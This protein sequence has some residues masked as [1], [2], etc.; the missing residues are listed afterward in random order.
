VKEDLGQKF[1]ALTAMQAVKEGF[2][3]GLNA[4]K[5]GLNAM[6]IGKAFDVLTTGA[7]GDFVDHGR[8]ELA[9]ALFHGADPLRD[10]PTWHTRPGQ[11][12]AVARGASARNHPKPGHGDVANRTEKRRLIFFPLWR[13]EPCSQLPRAV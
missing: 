8:T 10:V 6:G 1:E 5:D 13:Y 3:E 7:I 4:Y 2:K 9:A 12:T 11:G